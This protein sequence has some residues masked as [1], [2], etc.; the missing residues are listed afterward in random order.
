MI[1]LLIA[2][3][4]VRH[5]YKCHHRIKRP[6]ISLE[7]V[8]NRHFRGLLFCAVWTI[9]S[10]ATI[11]RYWQLWSLFYKTFCLIVVFMWLISFA[12]VIVYMSVNPNWKRISG[13]RKFFECTLV[14]SK[15]DHS[16]RNSSVVNNNNYTVHFM[17][18]IIATIMLHYTHW[19]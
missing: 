12:N 3:D 2:R 14:L 6:K 19:S 16:C 13:V 8:N 4:R 17:D 18:N 10:T 9:V 5:Q 15:N 11:R 7:Q 1:M